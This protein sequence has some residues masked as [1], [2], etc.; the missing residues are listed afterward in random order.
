ML[1]EMEVSPL[2]PPKLQ[3]LLLVLPLLY[4]YY[5]YYLLLTIISVSFSSKEDLILFLSASTVTLSSFSS[6]TL[7]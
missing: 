7:N 1:G 6:G 2:A 4:Y 5:Y 3:S